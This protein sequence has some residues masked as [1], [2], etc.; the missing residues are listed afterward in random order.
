MPGVNHSK[1]LVAQPSMLHNSY[2]IITL[3]SV[4]FDSVYLESMT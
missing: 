4:T 1:A 3:F 2:V